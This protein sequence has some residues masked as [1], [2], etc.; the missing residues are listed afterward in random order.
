TFSSQGH[1]PSRTYITLPLRKDLLPIATAPGT[2]QGDLAAEF[3]DETTQAWKPIGAMA[4]YDPGLQTLTFDISIRDFKMLAATPAALMSLGN[5]RPAAL[6]NARGPVDLAEYEGKFDRMFRA[7]HKERESEA[8]CNGDVFHPFTIAFYR[9]DDS[10]NR[11]ILDN[12]KYGPSHRT[13]PFSTS[14]SMSPFN[15]ILDLE[16]ALFTAH[17]GLTNIHTPSDAFPFAPYR[18]RPVGVSV[19][20]TGANDGE[21]SFDG[22]VILSNTRLTNWFKVKEVAAH[23]LVHCY[24]GAVY[25]TSPLGWRLE[26]LQNRWFIE[27]TAQYYSTRVCGNAADS[28]MPAVARDADRR[29]IYS[30]D[31]GQTYLIEYLS[32]SILT[33][34]DNSMYAVGHF[35]EYLETQYPG[36]VAEVLFNRWSAS[37]DISNLEAA[38]RKRSDAFDFGAGVGKSL[39]NYVN[40]VVSHPRDLDGIGYRIKTSLQA[41]TLANVDTLGVKTPLPAAEFTD[42]SE[43]GIYRTYFRLEKRMEALSATYLRFDAKLVDQ[44]SLLVLKAA[45]NARDFHHKAWT[46]V[47]P[48]FDPSTGPADPD[49]VNRPPIDQGKA[50]PYELA[51]TVPWF[52]GG[53]ASQVGCVEQIIVNHS[54]AYNNVFTTFD[55]LVTVHYYLLQ[56]PRVVGLV[57]RAGGG[58]VV[59]NTSGVGTERG[60][61]GELIKGYDVY[62]K[63]T[64]KLNT[65][66]I[67]LP[68]TPGAVLTFESDRLDPTTTRAAD[69]TVVLSDIVGNSWPPVTSV[70]IEPSSCSMGLNNVQSF[71]ATVE[72]AKNKSVTWSIKEGSLGGQ[73]FETTA[74]T[75]KYR[76]P[77]DLAG[78]NHIVAT[79]VE[80]SK[81]WAE[82]TV[83]VKGSIDVRITSSSRSVILGES[84]NLAFKVAGVANK[85]VT[86]HVKEG[87]NKGS[88][89]FPAPGSV[90]FTPSVLENNLTLVATSNADKTIKGGEVVFVEFPIDI[91]FTNVTDDTTEYTAKPRGGVPPYSDFV[92]YYGTRT[93][94]MSKTTNGNPIRVSGTARN[95]W[96]D[97]IVTAKDS[98]GHNGRGRDY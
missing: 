21:T 70:Q 4:F 92:W 6:S 53:A 3:W 7:Y 11:G 49:Y 43:K 1:L 14:C 25:D 90:V 97:I 44:D 29:L 77:T 18:T 2:L 58:A 48:S 96:Y 57:S 60:I 98:A 12:L 84:I 34:S 10:A 93:Y 56:R 83:V 32:K 41:A 66:P 68:Q 23:E 86:W 13:Q 42:K 94:G 30:D 71:T 65:Q 75:T 82:A 52:G 20:P 27:A 51:V 24:Q 89:A 47:L 73:L 45:G 17:L 38:I 78:T 64:G 59:W 76:S 37:S 46:Y 81:A 33:A 36:I 74:T 16:S 40:Y 95:S 9:P 61:P 62:L 63:G 31:D 69:V 39:A 5:D 28:W 88:F 67:P 22:P 15:F 87:D 91:T 8:R 72:G 79:S 19:R 50:F 26:A 35:L 85:E 55:P 80:D 54:R